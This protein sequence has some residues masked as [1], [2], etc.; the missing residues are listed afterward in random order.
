MNIERT[1]EFIIK[2]V[3]EKLNILIDVVDRHVRGNGHH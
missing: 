3:S 1:I 2:E